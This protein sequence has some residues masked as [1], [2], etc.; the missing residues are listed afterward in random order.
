MTESH[1]KKAPEG[2]LTCPFAALDETSQVIRRKDLTQLGGTFKESLSPLTSILEHMKGLNARWSASNKQL[3]RV[4]W[5]QLG[6]TV[7]TLTCLVV[8]LIAL[9]FSWEALE[10]VQEHTN[11]LGNLEKQFDA[12]TKKLKELETV[13][14]TTEKKVEQ[15]QEEQDTKPTLE[16]VPE[17]DPVKARRAPVKLRVKAPVRPSP[18]PKASMP[19]ENPEVSSKQAPPTMAEIPL[20]AES[21]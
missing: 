12:Q 3:K 10:L 19:K 4:T 2:T 21:F 15:V 7:M 8:L 17:T 13:A 1:P 11:T 16:L 20:S 6:I 5:F 14:H 9:R 18:E